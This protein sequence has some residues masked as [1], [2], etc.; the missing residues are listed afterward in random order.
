MGGN[1]YIKASIIVVLIYFILNI[2]ATGILPAFDS[3]G[4]NYIRMFVINIFVTFITLILSKHMYINRHYELAMKQADILE[5]IIKII[6]IIHVIYFGIIFCRN[7]II[8]SSFMEKQEP[9]YYELKSNYAI[10]HS[11][12]KASSKYSMANSNSDKARI[13][14]HNKFMVE[15]Y[16]L[17]P[18]IYFIIPNAIN[19]VIA[20]VIIKKKDDLLF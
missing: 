9:F 12:P 7:N 13:I 4:V 11:N 5:L 1:K 18:F 10:H 20:I 3:I 17:N 14:E 15:K 8:T 16:M 2:V 6:V 19:M